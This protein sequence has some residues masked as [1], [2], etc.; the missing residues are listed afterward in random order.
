MPWVKVVWNFSLCSNFNQYNLKFLFLSAHLRTIRFHLFPAWSALDSQLVVKTPAKV[1]LVAR[2]SLE[3]N[4]LVSSH[5][6]LDVP[7]PTC[8]EFMLPLETCVLGLL[9][10]PVYKDFINHTYQWKFEI[11][12]LQFTLQLCFIS[13]VNFLEIW[14][15]FSTVFLIHL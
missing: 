5:G 3:A 15:F 6:V 8:Q 12:I 1:T 2:W 14:I 11:N 7:D 9:Y 4:W 13:V 10:R